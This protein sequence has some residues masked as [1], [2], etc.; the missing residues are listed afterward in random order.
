MTNTVKER[1]QKPDRKDKKAAAYFQ[2]KLEFSETDFFFFQFRMK[3][4]LMKE[5]KNKQK[6]K[7]ISL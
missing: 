1:E 2:E 5:F 3:I 7:K 6:Q 4:N